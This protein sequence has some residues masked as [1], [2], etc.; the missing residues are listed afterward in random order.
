[1]ELK[2]IKKFHFEDLNENVVAV[3]LMYKGMK[4]NV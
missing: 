4:K 1:M 3:V 2:E